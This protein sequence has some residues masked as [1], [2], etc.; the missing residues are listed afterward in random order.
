M[1]LKWEFLTKND[2]KTIILD[3]KRS[4][5]ENFDRWF[6]DSFL[7]GLTGLSRNL[8]LTGNRRRPTQPVTISASDEVIQN[9][10]LKIAFI[11]VK[12]HKISSFFYSLIVQIYTD[13]WPWSLAHSRFYVFPHPIDRR[14]YHSTAESRDLKMMRIYLDEKS[15]F[16]GSAVERRSV[17]RRKGGCPLRTAHLGGDHAPYLPNGLP[18]KKRKSYTCVFLEHLVVC[19]YHKS[20]WW[21]LKNHYNRWEGGTPRLGVLSML[22]SKQRSAQWRS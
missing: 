21:R 12:K 9:K 22:Q 6:L 16:I 1:K 15:F 18:K 5:N 11:K 10:I 3:K 20:H 13:A 7:F 19:L 14:T 4:I 2:Q 8:G 17:P